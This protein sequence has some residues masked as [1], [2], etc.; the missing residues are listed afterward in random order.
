MLLALS[1]ALHGGPR[2]ESHG[3][4]SSCTKKV[5]VRPAPHSFRRSSASSPFHPIPPVNVWAT[6]AR[7]APAAGAAAGAEAGAAADAAAA[8]TISLV[9]LTMS[10]AA[11]FSAAAS[12]LAT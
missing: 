12:K 4:L 7:A 1:A 2:Y 5:P 3:N 6:V 9:F 11:F 8:A 10:A